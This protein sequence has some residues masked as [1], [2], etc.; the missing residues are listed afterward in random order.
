MSNIHRVFTNRYIGNAETHFLCN[1]WDTIHPA[2]VPK[3]E[4]RFLQIAFTKL[5]H[6]LEAY[7]EPHRHYHTPKHI[8]DLLDVFHHA[9]Q[10]DPKCQELGASQGSLVKLAIFYHD[11]VY[12]LGRQN[13]EEISAGKAQR[14]M[15]DMGFSQEEITIVTN[16]ILATWYS[17]GNTPKTFLEQIVVDCDFSGFALPW[18]KYLEQNLRVHKEFGGDNPSV[19][20][21]TK[22][23]EFLRTVLNKEHLFYTDLFQR[24]EAIAR[25]N[26]AR[27][28]DWISDK[29]HMVFKH[30]SEYK[31]STLGTTPARSLTTAEIIKAKYPIR[32]YLE[33]SI[34]EDMIINGKTQE[35]ALADYVSNFTERKTQLLTNEDIIIEENPN[36]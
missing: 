1:E 2:E 27:E 31:G 4:P 24:A 10:T 11:Y 34:R 35:Q 13:N 9:E 36:A 15:K 28:I 7:T 20:F 14:D 17:K 32:Q 3:D 12:V 6:L 22:R 23:I 25:A 18:E 21:Y 16:A 19:E 8:Y 33:E 26:V 29:L 5:I 30:D